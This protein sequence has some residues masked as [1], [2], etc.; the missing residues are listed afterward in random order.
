[1]LQGCGVCLSQPLQYIAWLP[2]KTSLQS[3]QLC[4][5]RRKTSF[6]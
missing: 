1:M 3:D 4:R 5:L 2:V 6:S